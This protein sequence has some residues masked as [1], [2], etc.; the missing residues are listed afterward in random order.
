MNKSVKECGGEEEKEEINLSKAL[1]MADKLKTYCLRKLILCDHPQV[2][3]IRNCRQSNEFYHQKA[4]TDFNVTI[5][6]FLEGN[7]HFDQPTFLL[8]I[9]QFYYHPSTREGDN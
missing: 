8:M 7:M 2:P 5:T 3:S 6:L 9:R 4:P 1:K